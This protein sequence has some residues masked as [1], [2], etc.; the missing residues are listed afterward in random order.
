MV[1]VDGCIIRGKLE[2]KYDQAC[3]VLKDGSILAK[4][5]FCVSVDL[6]FVS[7][8]K[9]T[10]KR[11]QH[12]QWQI[13]PT[14][15]LGKKTKKS[16]KEEK[17]VGQAKKRPPS[18]PRLAQGLDLPLLPPVTDIYLKNIIFFRETAGKERAS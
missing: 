3:S 18:S 6:A 16:Q 13:S 1:T 14:P 2:K 9:Q 11:D 7:V 17:P 8:Y 10:I 15:I 5:F 4:F 12:L